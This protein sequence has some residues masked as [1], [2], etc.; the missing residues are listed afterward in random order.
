MLGPDQPV[1]LH[2]LD[3]PMM[4]NALKGCQME[5]QD[6]A[7]PLLQ[8]VVLCTDQNKGFK[9]VDYALLLGSKPRGPGMERADLLKDNG[10][11]FVDTGKA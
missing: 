11:I 4:E 7:F 5:L 8:E 1:I 9:D 6:C 3:L 2:M 10:K